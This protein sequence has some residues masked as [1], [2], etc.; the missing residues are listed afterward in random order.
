[1]WVEIRWC[2][3][4]LVL[5]RRYASGRVVGVIISIFRYVL[6]CKYDLINET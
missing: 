4:S 1:M 3:E 6:Y 5:S 2:L